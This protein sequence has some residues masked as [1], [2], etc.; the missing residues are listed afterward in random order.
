MATANLF[1]KINWKKV[2]EDSRVQR[3][4]WIFNPPASPWW[5]GFWERL[6]RVVKEFLRKLL[7]HN[8]LTKTELDTSICFVESLMN[9]RPLTYVSDDPDD[10]VPLTPAAFLQDIEQ[11]EFPESVEGRIE[12]PVS[13]ASTWDS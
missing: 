4:T 1:G 5:G 2:H 6:I 7:G 12:K 3:I 13:V 10:L 9:G 11:T 8:K